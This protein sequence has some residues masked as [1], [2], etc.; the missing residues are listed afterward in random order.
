MSRRRAH[1]VRPYAHNRIFNTRKISGEIPGSGH[2]P[3]LGTAVLRG[4]P[5]KSGR[6]FC[7]VCRLTNVQQTH[8]LL[9]VRNTCAT[10]EKEGAEWQVSVMK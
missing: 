4:K 7:A 8:M 5:A 1:N 9:L 6:L 2:P 3:M 10:W